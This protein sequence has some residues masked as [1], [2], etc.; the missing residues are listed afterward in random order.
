[1]LVF[2]HRNRERKKHSYAQDSRVH[3]LA[4][5]FLLLQWVTPNLTK[6]VYTCHHASVEVMLEENTALKIPT[7][8]LSHFYNIWE[9]HFS[10]VLILKVY[11]N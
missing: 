9:K 1:V 5:V 4:P 7:V 6:G 8:S 10:H 2:E 3:C 11:K